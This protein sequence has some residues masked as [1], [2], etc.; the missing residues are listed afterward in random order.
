MQTDVVKY[1]EFTHYFKGY[2]AYWGVPT[3]NIIV[4]R[5]KAEEKK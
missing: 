3:G 4:H 2:R 5:Y 1:H